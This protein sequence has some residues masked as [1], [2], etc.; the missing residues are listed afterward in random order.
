[1][2]ASAGALK[3]LQSG[4]TQPD[5]PQYGLHDPFEPISVTFA[6]GSYNPV[7][8]GKIA[9]LPLETPGHTPGAL[10]WNWWS[11]ERTNC[12]A[13]VY[14]DSLSPISND[15]YLFKDHPE[16]LAQYQMGLA[17]LAE[18]PCDILL[19]PHPSA[20]KMLKRMADTG[21]EGGMDCRA[22][23]QSI[24]ARLN[25]RLAEEANRQ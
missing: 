3:A 2:I 4:E 9:L 22:Y 11:C 20:S 8:T 13:I 6:I 5:D 18:L 16:Y 15:E 25:K 19:A 21:L 10:S 23:A 14:A 12:K 7:S 17:A 24:E 1:M